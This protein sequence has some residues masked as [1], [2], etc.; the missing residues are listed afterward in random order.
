MKILLIIVAVT[1]V[2]TSIYADY[3]WKQWIAAR[4]AEREG[5][6]PN[7]PTPR[8]H[9]LSAAVQ[10]VT[11]AEGQLIHKDEAADLRMVDRAR[12]PLQ[13][14]VK[15]IARRADQIVQLLAEGVS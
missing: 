8:A 5:H 7:H 6:V 13:T 15:G 14:V 9:H 1:L 3:K 11:G 4:K 12:P 10:L 2:A